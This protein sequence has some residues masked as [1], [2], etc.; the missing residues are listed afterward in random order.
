MRSS[1]LMGWYPPEGVHD[2]MRLNRRSGAQSPRPALRS[3]GYTRFS[4]YTCKMGRLKVSLAAVYIPNRAHEAD[5]VHFPLRRSLGTAH[6]S[7]LLFY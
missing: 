3:A 2:P 6:F 4:V 5:G 7:V 1:G